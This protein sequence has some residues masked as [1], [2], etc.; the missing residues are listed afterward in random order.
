L[1]AA[2]FRSFASPLAIDRLT[3]SMVE[4]GS[5]VDCYSRP[6]GCATGV[7]EQIDTRNATGQL[8]VFAS[9]SQ[10]GEGAIGASGAAQTERKAACAPWRGSFALRGSRCG[11]TPRDSQR[12][13]K[14]D[15]R[16]SELTTA[17]EMR[18]RLRNGRGEGIP[19]NAIQPGAVIGAQTQRVVDGRTGLLL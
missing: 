7:G 16:W 10:R 18:K 12:A 14:A 6:E 19:L 15:T 3:R 9:V 2:R 1:R 4:L 5:L 17:R 8:D 13:A 11:K